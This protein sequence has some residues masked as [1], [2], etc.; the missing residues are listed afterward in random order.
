[1]SRPRKKSLVRAG[2]WYGEKVKLPD[3]LGMEVRLIREASDPILQAG[4]P[5]IDVFEEEPP[6]DRTPIQYP[7]VLTPS[8]MTGLTEESRFRMSWGASE[9]IAQILRG[10]RLSRAINNSEQPGYLK[11]E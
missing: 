7:R 1:M 4:L 10:E 9:Q 2:G 6:R 5:A 11:K 8:R 3:D